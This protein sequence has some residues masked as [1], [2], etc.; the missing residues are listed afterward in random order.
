MTHAQARL[1]AG[2]QNNGNQNRILK[3]E[4]HYMFE[5][6]QNYVEWSKWD[7]LLRE[8][9]RSARR[10]SPS[11]PRMVIITPP[12]SPESQQ[13]AEIPRH[14]Y[15]DSRRHHH[16]HRDSR[17]RHHH[18]DDDDHFTR[19]S[20]TMRKDESKRESHHDHHGQHHGHHHHDSHRHHHHHHHRHHDTTDGDTFLRQT[21]TTTTTTLTDPYRRHALMEPEISQ[22][23]MVDGMSR[24]NL[25]LGGEQPE[26]AMT[27]DGICN[28]FEPRRR[29]TE[30]EYESD[31]YHLSKR[32]LMK[33][34]DS[35][36]QHMDELGFPKT[37]AAPP[38]LEELGFPSTIDVPEAN[39]TSLPIMPQSQ[40]ESH[41][42]VGEPRARSDGVLMPYGESGMSKRWSPK[43]LVCATN[44]DSLG[45]FPTAGEGAFPS[46]PKS[47]THTTPMLPPPPDFSRSKRRLMQRE[48]SFESLLSAK[49]A[50][51][52]Y[53]PLDSEKHDRHLEDIAR[54]K[55]Q[56][57]RQHHLH[58]QQHKEFKQTM[59]KLLE[60]EY[61]PYYVKRG[62]PSIL[63][64]LTGGSDDKPE[65]AAALSPAR[66]ASWTSPPRRKGSRR[67]WFER[68]ESKKGKMV[69][70]KPRPMQMVFFETVKGES[71]D[72]AISTIE[73]EEGEETQEESI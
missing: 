51:A 55:E 21:P 68:S 49:T 9:S 35:H 11:P 34:D 37:T 26:R 7:R 58:S 13:D 64:H 57:R 6:T 17:H 71:F 59:K 42:S 5:E 67:A 27:D 33:V 72:T 15:K 12:S 62:P 54:Q 53:L 1:S 16:H 45:A 56:L 70:N 18:D 10:D 28:D 66:A 36:S 65:A 32:S 31:S 25:F 60:E 23:T 22:R 47:P 29:W 19:E 20:E 38:S 14:H 52:V 69:S 30:F 3:E 41:L 43:R 61:S 50:P 63:S 4:K 46:I 73:E 44:D 40:S 39:A 2:I 8:G 48:G 24:L